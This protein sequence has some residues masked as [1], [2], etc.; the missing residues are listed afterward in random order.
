MTGLP[1][2]REHPAK[3]KPPSGLRREYRPSSADNECMLT[4]PSVQVYDSQTVVP[5][6]QFEYDHNGGDADGQRGPGDPPLTPTSAAFVDKVAVKKGPA[7]TESSPF[8]AKLLAKENYHR[9]PDVG[10]SWAPRVGKAPDNAPAKAKSLPFQPIMDDGPT[11][12]SLN[13]VANQAGSE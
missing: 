13:D 8:T 11:V 1:P 12:G 3:Q 5:E 10:F 7:K 6:T 2:G 9:P 4:E